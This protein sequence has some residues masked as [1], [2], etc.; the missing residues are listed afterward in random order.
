[1]IV[2]QALHRLNLHVS[3]G[4]QRDRLRLGLGQYTPG[5]PANRM[6]AHLQVEILVTSKFRNRYKSL[7][8]PQGSSHVSLTRMLLSVII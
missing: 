5:Q 7:S 4:Q 3:A 1:M 2:G 8:L 6:Q